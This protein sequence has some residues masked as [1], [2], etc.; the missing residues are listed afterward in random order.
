VADIEDVMS[1]L[2]LAVAKISRLQ[3]SVLEATEAPV[4]QEH[5]ATLDREVNNAWQLS[6]DIKQKILRLEDQPATGYEERVK[7]NIVSDLCSLSSIAR[8]PTS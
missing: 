6:L 7:R 8:F 5:R 1:D 2:S 3:A 4:A